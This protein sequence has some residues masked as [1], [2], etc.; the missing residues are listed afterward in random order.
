MNLV[1]PSDGDSPA[2]LT[3]DGNDDVFFQVQDSG[4]TEGGYKVYGLDSDGASW[5]LL[6][7]GSSNDGDGDIG[8]GDVMLPDDGGE[9]E[10]MVVPTGPDDVSQDVNINLS[11]DPNPVDPDN[12]SVDVT[13][14]I[15]PTQMAGMW[16]PL[17]WTAENNPPAQ[18]TITLAE[19]TTQSLPVAFSVGGTAASSDYSLSVSVGSLDWSSGSTSGTVTIPAG[20]DQATVTISATDMPAN[21]EE[22]DF[23]LITNGQPYGIDGTYN[24][25]A[26]T[27]LG[28]DQGDGSTVSSDGLAV[29]VSASGDS[30]AIVT[31][32]GTSEVYLQAEDSATSGCGYQ[33]YQC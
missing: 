25:A 7:D 18:V 20:S 15:T 24:S 19:T 1:V 23:S 22:V 28:S 10:L 3:L 27:L 30:P 29:E 17:Q 6:V 5:D 9:D 12:T 8:S 2:I 33:V 21:Y 14:G 4:P 32:Y 26:V 16:S 11:D 13:F 31:V